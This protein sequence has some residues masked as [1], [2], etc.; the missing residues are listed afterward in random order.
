ME[1]H[2]DTYW[3]GDHALPQPQ[4][5]T[6]PGIMKLIVKRLSLGEQLQLDVSRAPQ[7]DQ[8]F[9][10][11]MYI[12]LLP[13]RFNNEEVTFRWIG[14][15]HDVNGNPLDTGIGQRYIKMEPDPQ[16]MGTADAVEVQLFNG[17]V[18]SVNLGHFRLFANSEMYRGDFCTGIIDNPWVEVSGVR[19][20]ASDGGQLIR[21]TL[22]ASATCVSETQPATEPLRILSS[23]AEPS[24]YEW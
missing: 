22:K 21:C 20:S 3:L 24:R 17:D 19:T 15:G 1:E 4:P 2:Y 6:L 5:D 9:N 18:Y 7:L 8:T 16:Q 13:L 23:N 11:T 10:N 14:R 12:G